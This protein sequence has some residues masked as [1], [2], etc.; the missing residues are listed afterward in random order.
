MVELSEQQQKALDLM[1]EGSLN[2]KQIAKEV[3]VAYQTVRKWRSTNV[4]FKAE[5][6]SRHRDALVEAQSLLQSKVVHAMKRMI[7][8][9]DDPKANRINFQA[10]KAVIDLANMTTILEFQEEVEQLKEALA[11]RQV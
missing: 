6:L 1:I 8:M 2:L 7:E 10:C 5:L 9:M 3:G 11:E 4:E